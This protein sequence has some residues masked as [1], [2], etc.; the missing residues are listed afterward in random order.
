MPCEKIY[1]YSMT[2]SSHI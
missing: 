1:N 2:S